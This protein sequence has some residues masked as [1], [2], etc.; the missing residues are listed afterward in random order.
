M[1]RIEDHEREAAIAKGVRQGCSLS[2]LLFNLYIEQA[3]K[4]IKERFGKGVTIQ[5][6]E[7]KT[8]RFA[9]DIVIISE[10]VDDLEELLNGMDNVLRNEYKMNINRNKTQVMECSRIKTG[11]A[12]MVQL[13]KDS[14]KEVNEFCYLG[15]RITSDGRSK[16]DIKCR[17][18]QARKAFV[19]KRNLLTSN[20][21]LGIRKTFLKVF[22]WSVALYG[23]ETWTISS[24]EKKRI[25]AFEMW[26]YRRMLK[27]RWV[28]RITNEEV[29]RRMDENRTLWKTL[30]RRRDRLVGHV[31][32][33]QGLTNLVLEGSVGRKNSRGRPRQ[34]YDTQ[35]R[36]DVGCSS[37]EQMKRLAQDRR[38]WRAA[39]NQS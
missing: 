15:S 38:A 20:I 28:D 14:L 35:I 4:E 21:S 2:P 9:D 30:T 32:R 27:I 37:Y 34:E 26:C 12:G 17:L 1:L 36:A 31:L 3:L 25:E 19:R 23:C 5:G 29:L 11:D 7:I 10:S 13:G 6:E 24:T 16:T 33:H 18:A 8:L 39:S 22:V